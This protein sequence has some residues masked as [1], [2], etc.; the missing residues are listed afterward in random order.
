MNISYALV[1]LHN[2]GTHKS[3]SNH[4]ICFIWEIRIH[5]FSK[6]TGRRGTCIRMYFFAIFAQ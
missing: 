1:S 4:N 5:T 2:L 6:G 3:L